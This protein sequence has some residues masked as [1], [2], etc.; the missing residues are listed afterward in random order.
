MREQASTNTAIAP[1]SEWIGPA[2]P[3]GAEVPARYSSSDR[4]SLV[5]Q[6]R[7]YMGNI[8]LECRTAA[9]YAAS[10]PGLTSEFAHVTF[11]Q[12][13]PIVTATDPTPPSD[14][15][16][17][18]VNTAPTGGVPSIM[19]IWAALEL[20][21]FTNPLWKLLFW[22][23]DPDQG[24]ASIFVGQFILH[25]VTHL[26]WSCMTLRDRG[27]QRW[28]NAR[29]FTASGGAWVDDTWEHQ[30]INS[31][32]VAYSVVFGLDRLGSYFPVPGLVPAVVAAATA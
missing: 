23:P 32:Q 29:L 15:A 18:Y 30:L 7:G 8:S 11:P 3:A 28:Q 13:T 27:D 14:A 20:A 16:R 6:L 5:A 17:V 21:I 12:N 1:S 19:Q 25:E 24:Y 22:S 26:A 4:A 9:Q 31:A 2:T 10:R